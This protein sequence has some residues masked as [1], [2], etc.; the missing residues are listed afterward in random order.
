VSAPQAP[1]AMLAKELPDWMKVE[2]LITNDDWAAEQKFDGHRMLVMIT[3]GNPRAFN[4]L[5]TEVRVPDTLVEDLSNPGFSENWILDG[6]YMNGDYYVFD[7]PVSDVAQVT[8]DTEHEDRKE[9][10][11]GFFPMWEPSR[12]H[13]VPTSYTTKQ[14]TKL[15][16]E[17]YNNHLEG[18]V[19]KKFCGKYAPGKRTL[20]VVKYKFVETADAMVVEVNR[21]GKERAITLGMFKN[22]IQIDVG[23]CKIPDDQIGVIKVGDVV[24]VKY[25]YAT[26]DYKVYQPRFLKVRTDKTPAQCLVSQLKLTNKDFVVDKQDDN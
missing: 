5:G 21:K 4:R 1:V 13:L 26:S 22:G 7:C 25:L 24:E 19:F 11:D 6:E 12:C 3:D 14:K 15:F 8:C 17:C 2:D 16:E 10:L 23:G 20:S 18:L 9:F